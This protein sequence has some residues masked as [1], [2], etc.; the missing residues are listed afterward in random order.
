MRNK[1]RLVLLKTLSTIVATGVLAS[2]FMIPVSAESF[3]D[4][5]AMN[6]PMM[7]SSV[8]NLSDLGVITG[9]PDET[10]RPYAN[11]SRAETAAMI[12]RLM[13]LDNI[14]PTDNTG[15]PDVDSSCFASGY[16]KILKERGIIMGNENGL[17]NPNDSI[18]YNEFI[19]IV[20]EI[21]EENDTKRLG[22]SYPE[23]YIN[24]AKELKILD[25]ISNDDLSDLNQKISR[26]NAAVI[27]N[28]VYKL[29]LIEPAPVLETAPPIEGVNSFAMKMNNEIIKT[30]NY[31]FSPL[32][33]KM[34]MAMTANGA[35]GE[36]QKEILSTL[37][38]DN[39]D[40]Y[41][42]L[43]QK[44][45]NNYN[46]NFDYAGYNAL[47][48]KVNSGDYDDAAFDKLR[49]YEK[50]LRD[51]ETT[52]MNIANSIWVNDDYYKNANVKFK[53]DFENTIKTNYLGT[54]EIVNKDNAVETINNW[55]NNKTNGKIPEIINDNDFLAALVN[56]IYF[57]AKWDKEFS[58]SKT[59][60]GT[61]TNANGLEVNVPFMN[62]ISYYNHYK[63]SNIQMIKLPYLGNKASM[64]ISLDDGDIENYDYY[65]NKLENTYVDLS[66]PKFKIEYSKKINES[67]NNLG[68]KTVFDASKADFNNML[69]NVPVTENVY[70]NQ[71]L[72]KT[73]ISVDEKGTEAAAVTAVM[74]AGTGAPVFPEPIKFSA[75]RPFTFIIC[76]EASG[77]ILFI[78]R[79]AI[80]EK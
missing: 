73:Y 4:V 53:T 22:F 55:T 39:L 13:E 41:N 6:N 48:D 9:Y 24:R 14:A 21:I 18:S 67:L 78:G 27:L 11:I 57:N 23:D 66:L 5:D 36:T 15:F 63:D 40:E 68:I 42:K 74:M 12:C 61:F 46:S 3:A 79:Y 33:V 76:D 60:D 29:S 75:N 31:M 28:N 71:V 2:S 59:K 52:V 49:E 69:E 62:Q 80:A 47:A 30:E 37:G 38:I 32:S 16:I 7:S 34:A 20:V 64:Y 72:H 25:G 54:S 70:I 56:A 10:F 44:L 1:L 58:E 77:E 65:I 26:I 51:G 50:Q 43:A 8:D 45:I 19:K 35:D 17:Y